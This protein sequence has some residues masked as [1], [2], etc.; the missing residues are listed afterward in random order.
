MSILLSTLKVNPEFVNPQR[1]QLIRKSHFDPPDIDI[2]DEEIGDFRTEYTKFKVR[3]E[4]RI[5][6]AH[7]NGFLVDEEH[8]KSLVTNL[9]WGLSPNGLI[10]HGD[11]KSLF[12][13]SYRIVQEGLREGKIRPH[14][15]ILPGLTYVSD[16]LHR[17]VYTVFAPGIDP[18][19]DSDYRPDLAESILPYRVWTYWNARGRR[20]VS[21][22]SLLLNHEYAHS[23]EELSDLS[24]MASLRS[25][26]RKHDLYFDATDRNLLCE[27]GQDRFLQSQRRMMVFGEAVTLV[28]PEMSHLLPQFICDPCMHGTNQNAESLIEYLSQ[29]ND[30][31][32]K[33]VVIRTLVYGP[34][35]L[36]RSGAALRDNNH[37]LIYF[38]V[39]NKLLTNLS[40]AAENCYFLSNENNASYHGPMLWVAY[41]NTLHNSLY[42]IE[43]LANSLGWKSSPPHQF[44][45]QV[46]SF[47]EDIEAALLIDRLAR[48]QVG[49]LNA[50]QLGITRSRVISDIGVVGMTEENRTK[51]WLDSFIHPKSKMAELIRCD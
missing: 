32:L 28:K 22:S 10:P 27:K 15:I 24:Y 43:A 12:V 26:Y 47:P 41:I 3:I 44:Q 20:P 42:E 9:E 19:P 14:E 7:Q 23:G 11:A 2:R 33:Q 16:R 5:A 48:F 49:I 31:E 36:M 4:P 6:Y 34:Q 35:C 40:E 37:D 39:N 21:F 50:Y 46:F 30:D 51:K 29:L 45:N 38:E 18:A 25:V 13:N 1:G 17:E 8:S